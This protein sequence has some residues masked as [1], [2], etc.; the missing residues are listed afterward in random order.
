MHLSLRFPSLFIRSSIHP[1]NHLC[2]HLSIFLLFSQHL[3]PSS[4]AKQTGRWCCRLSPATQS[5]ASVGVFHHQLCRFTGLSH[6]TCC[7]FQRACLANRFKSATVH[8]TPTPKWDSARQR[9][10]THI[11]DAAT[12]PPL[13]PSELLP[14]SRLQ[15]QAALILDSRHCVLLRRRRSHYQP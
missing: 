8:K 4:A 13:L 15:Q 1:S 2:I 5:S 9:A 10:A 11:A 7:L 14:C 12:P 6:A 3:L